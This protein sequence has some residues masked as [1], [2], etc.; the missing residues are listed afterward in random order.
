[1]ARNKHGYTAEELD[2]LTEEELAGL[3]DES[4]VDEGA[5]LGADDDD[6]DEPAAA[7]E[8]VDEEPA[9]PTA[10]PEKPAAPSDAE[11]PKAPTAAAPVASAEEVPADQPAPAAAS[12]PEPRMLPQYQVPADAKDKIKNLDAQLDELAKKFDDGELTATEYRQ[13]MGPLESEKQDLRELLL[14]QSLSMDSQVA[15]WTNV[16]VPKFLGDHKEYEPG[17]PLYNALNDEVKRLQ[18]ESDNPFNAAFLET[19]HR[20]VQASIRKSLGLPP[21]PDETKKTATAPAA[22]R[23]IPPTLARLP[24]ADIA[25]AADGG[26]FAYLDRLADKD[27]LAYEEALAKLPQDKLDAYLAAG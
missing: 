5:N 24:A 19:A 6:D 23:E 22:K 17:T 4:I 27:P 7:V 12:Q 2:L 10:Q 26:E 9:A 13:Q 15:T 11:T 18:A 1:M 14:K 20:N 16:T 25:E 3:E 8:P 21:L